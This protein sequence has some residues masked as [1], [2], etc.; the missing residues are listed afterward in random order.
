MMKRQTLNRA[1]ML[2]ALIAGFAAAS[3]QIRADSGTCSGQMI[4]VPFTDVASSPFFCSIAEAYFSG[5]TNGTSPTTYSPSQNVP[6]DQMAAFITRTQDSAL[7]RGS[8]RAALNQWDQGVFST[9]GSTTVGVT[10]LLVASDGEDLWVANQTSGTVSRVHGSDGRL[11]DSWT[12]ATSATGVLVARGRV[13]VTGNSSPGMLYRIDPG[14]AAGAVTVV[15]SNLG[16]FPRGVTTDGSSIWTANGANGD[17][18]G[19]SVSKVNPGTGDAQTFTTGIHVPRGILYDGNNI[20]VTDGFDNELKKL[21]SD[22]TIAFTVSV[23]NTP[24]VNYPV[25]D[26]TNIWVPSEDRVTVV[27]VKD[28]QGNPLATPFILATLTD[29][30]LNLAVQAAFDGQRIAVTN[31]L[32]NSISLWRAT[33]LTPL[34][35]FSAPSGSSPF[36]ACSD[37]IDFWIT[38]SGTDKLARF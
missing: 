17:P 21:N 34:G 19:G 2:L 7:R 10:P 8:R 27:R 9:G 26:G 25:F 1:T 20:W 38:L 16:N 33:D 37:G 28:S 12:G 3:S 6:R 11:L 24:T 15:S 4:T 13:F 31:Y 5:L 30:G 36:G 29:N 35:S 18:N 32:G 23:N 14:Q 22:G